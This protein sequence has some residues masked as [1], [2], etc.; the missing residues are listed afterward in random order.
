MGLFD[1]LKKNVSSA[2]K[3][4]VS[5]SFGDTINELTSSFKNVRSIVDE[6]FVRREP[7]CLEQIL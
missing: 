7:P 3:D 1:K 4:A 2:V 5:D 6:K